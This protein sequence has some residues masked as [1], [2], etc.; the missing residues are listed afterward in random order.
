MRKIA[1]LIAEIMI[2]FIL[3]PAT[4]QNFSKLMLDQIVER[5]H[6]GTGAVIPL[7]SDSLDNIAGNLL[8][9]YQSPVPLEVL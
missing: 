3:K 2:R 7:L 4:F 6:L 9:V 1:K 5:A 8:Q